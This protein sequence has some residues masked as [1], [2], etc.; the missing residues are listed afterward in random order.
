LVKQG[1]GTVE[2]RPEG[3][4]VFWATGGGHE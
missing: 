1:G 2:I 3:I 4:K